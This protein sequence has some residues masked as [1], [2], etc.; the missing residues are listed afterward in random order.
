MATMRVGYDQILFL[1]R[2]IHARLPGAEVSLFGSRVDDTKHGGD[3][4]ILVVADERLPLIDRI[5]V[6]AEYH[7]AFGMRKI[8]IVS[9]AKSERSAFRDVVARDAVLL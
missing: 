1:K 4:D 7:R 3:L 9:F 2:A 8:D 5:G 6:K